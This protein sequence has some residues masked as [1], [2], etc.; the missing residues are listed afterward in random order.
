M[1]Y[2]CTEV[3]NVHVHSMYY[4]HNDMYVHNMRIEKALI[5]LRA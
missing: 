4:L 2:V 3:T 5:L 1:I